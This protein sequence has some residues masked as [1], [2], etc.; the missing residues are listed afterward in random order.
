MSWDAQLA[1]VE[2]LAGAIEAR[3]GEFI[4]TTVEE[5]GFSHRDC[6]REVDLTVARLRAFDEARPLLA[7]RAPYCRAPE[8]SIALF[9]PYDGSTWLNIAIVSLLMVGNRVRV[10]FSSRGSRLSRLTETLYRD[11]FGDQVAFEYRPGREFMDDALADPTVRA[12]CFFGSDRNA[13]P[14]EGAVRASG[15]K[16]IF[17]GPGND[18]FIVLADADVEAALDDLMDAKYNY[19][20]QT[21]TAPERIYVHRSL[22]R[23]FVAEFASRSRSLPVGDPREPETVVAPLA[24]PLAVTN[25][26]AQIRDARERGGHIVCGGRVDGALVYPTVIADADHSMLGVREESFGPISFVMPFDDAQEAA[27]LAGDDRYGLR[28][29]VFGGQDAGAVAAALKGADYLEPV[30]QWIFGRFGTVG[31]NEPRRSSWVKALITKPIGGYGLSG[32]VWETREGRFI[33]RQGPKL[34]SVETST[35]ESGGRA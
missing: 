10:K 16:L 3:A 26:E 25:I 9:L 11:I 34:F 33:T 6:A 15:K 8:D 19:S 23:D 20:G 17:E 4:A 18:P 12:I 24:S 2:L 21:C 1:R 5:V 7:G 29:A 13:L 30:T 32:W 14:L 27:A 28:A 22:Y 35:A 31:I